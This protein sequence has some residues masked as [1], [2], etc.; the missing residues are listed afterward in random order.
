MSQGS[1]GGSKGEHYVRAVTFDPA[2]VEQFLRHARMSARPAC[3]LQPDSWL[4]ANASYGPEGL[5]QVY[6]AFD[7]VWA[8]R[9]WGP[10]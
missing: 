9:T 6:K 2:V 1:G 5:K 10:Q 8:I 7:N 3:L 4:I